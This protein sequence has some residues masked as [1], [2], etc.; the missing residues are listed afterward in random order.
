MHVVGRLP[1][2]GTAA[3]PAPNACWVHITTCLAFNLQ[4]FSQRA[5]AEECLC[6]PQHDWHDPR[7][8]IVQ[9]LNECTAVNQAKVLLAHHAADEHR[10]H[11]W[12]A[13]LGCAHV[14]LAPYEALATNTNTCRCWG[15]HVPVLYCH[16][17]QDKVN[18]CCVST[19]P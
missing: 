2:A 19:P 16:I 4:E 1:A 15:S 3:V 14:C 6:S 18:H 11:A 5:P 8:I 9:H 7:L 13:A 10:C 17:G 12:A